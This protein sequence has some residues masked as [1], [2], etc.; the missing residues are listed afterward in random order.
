M[1]TEGSRFLLGPR[2]LVVCGEVIVLFIS[3]FQIGLLYYLWYMGNIVL[4][5]GLS[6]LVSKFD[7]PATVSE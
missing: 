2:S 3:Q 5:I 7:I 6:F 4:L 1:F